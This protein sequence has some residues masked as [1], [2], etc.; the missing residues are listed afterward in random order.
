MISPLIAKPLQFRT[1]GESQLTIDDVK[2]QTKEIKRLDFL[3]AEKEKTEKKLKE[4]IMV[5]GIHKNLILLLGVVPSEGLVISEPESRI[6]FYNDNFEL[7]FQRE[8]EFHLATTP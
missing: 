3:K 5:D 6:F 8:S 4:D 2:A 1:S 7:V